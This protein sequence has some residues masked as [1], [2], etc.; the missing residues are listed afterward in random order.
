MKRYLVER[1]FPHGLDVPMNAEGRQTCGSVVSVNSP[2]GVTWIR[3]YVSPDGR[4]TWCLYEAPSPDAIRQVA[5][6]NGFP[7]GRITEVGLLSPHSF[8]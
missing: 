6:R 5:E 7:A 1:T 3:S 8:P 2:W 4:K